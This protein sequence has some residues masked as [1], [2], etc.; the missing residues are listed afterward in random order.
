[1]KKV[2]RNSGMWLYLE[3]LGVL[4]SGSDEQI[5]QAKLAYR[6]IYYRNHKRQ[7]RKEGLEVLICLNKLERSHLEREAK[8]HGQKLPTFI[9]EA[10]LSYIR[11]VYMVVDRKVVAHIQQLL[12]QT[13]HEIQVIAKQKHWFTNPS[14]FEKLEQ[15]IEKLDNE[16]IQALTKPKVVETKS[17]N[18][19]GNS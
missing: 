18:D 2:R 17:I 3:N 7:K 19:Y 10:T 4:S 11:Q 16:I 5:K 13:V 14:K 9:R 15:I 12:F 1:M 8:R 6:K